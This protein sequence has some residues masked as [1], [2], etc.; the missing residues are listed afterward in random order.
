MGKPEF[1]GGEL[2]GPSSSSPRR[3]SPTETEDVVYLED[4]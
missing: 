3:P 4:V 2:K 1:Y